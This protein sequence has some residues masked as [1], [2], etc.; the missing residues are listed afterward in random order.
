MHLEDGDRGDECLDATTILDSALVCLIA[1]CD[2]ML[3]IVQ[4]SRLKISLGNC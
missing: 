4:K 3:C 2:S 1:L